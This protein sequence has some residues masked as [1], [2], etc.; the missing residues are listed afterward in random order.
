LEK[1]RVGIVNYLNTKPLLVGLRKVEEAGQI[2]LIEDYPARIAALLIKK[3]IDLGLV[4][5][6]ALPTIP[7]HFIVGSYCISTKEEVGSV[8]LFSQQPIDNVRRVILDY[9]S[10]TSVQLARLLFGQFWKKEV[11][12]IPAFDEMYI[13]E[14]KGSTAGIIIG[15]RALEARSRFPYIY[16]LGIAWKAFTNLPF[17]FAVWAS[18]VPLSKEFITLFDNAN[19]LGFTQLKEV[20]AANQPATQYDLYRYYT[21]NIDYRLSAE[22]E[23]AIRLFLQKSEQLK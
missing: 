15:D 6:A 3:E 4:P 20:V 2:E 18:V 8:C 7:N 19:G 9:Q 16:D 10:K 5:V 14:I 17:V 22:K 13:G 1:I 21:T 23:E 12:F 11:E